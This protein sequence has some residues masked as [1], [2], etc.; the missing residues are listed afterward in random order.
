MATL[1][2]WEL[3]AETLEWVGPITVTVNGSPVTNFTLA[4]VEGSAR[5]VTFV[6]PD[7]DP[8]APGTAKGVIVG[9]GSTFPLLVGK[10]YTIFA[11]YSDSPEV[12]VERCG[13]IKVT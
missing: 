6:T 13:K 11:K 10:T 3:V 7:A 4:V 5:P 9:A 2:Q 12:P 1:T 8:D